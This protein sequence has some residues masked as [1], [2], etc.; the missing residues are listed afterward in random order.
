ME[1]TPHV[2]PPPLNNA[3]TDMINLPAFKRRAGLLS[4]CYVVVQTHAI[5]LK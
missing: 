4:G 2:A 1:I 5:V 3:S